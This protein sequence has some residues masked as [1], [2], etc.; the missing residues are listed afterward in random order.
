MAETPLEK[1]EWTQ[2]LAAAVAADRKDRRRGSGR[3][4]V[5]GP[6]SLYLRFRLR[7]LAEFF[8]V[9]GSGP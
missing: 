6:G 4:H 8:G 9:A 1:V 7:P 3:C 2:R 5:F